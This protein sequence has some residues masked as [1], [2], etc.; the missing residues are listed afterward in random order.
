MHRHKRLVLP[1]SPHAG[2]FWA[3]KHTLAS[4]LEPVKRE[5]RFEAECAHTHTHAHTHIHAHAYTHTQI[6]IKVIRTSYN[7][8]AS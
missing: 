3:S 7:K 1:G 8:L 5:P 6:S 4:A 2:T